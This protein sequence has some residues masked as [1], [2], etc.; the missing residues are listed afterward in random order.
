M[1]ELGPVL[2]GRWI[3]PAAQTRGVL[4]CYAELTPDAPRA[5]TTA[6]TATATGTRVTAIWSGSTA[7]A[8]V[9]V[10]PYGALGKPSSETFGG[11]TF[12]ELQSQSDE[13][14]AWGRRYY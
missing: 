10:R 13:H 12:L 2:V 4:R 11:M 7:G 5:L 14:F 8:E 9:A 3:Y 1:H 6:F